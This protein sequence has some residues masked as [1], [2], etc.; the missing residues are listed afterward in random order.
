M[1]KYF[2]LIVTLLLLGGC[3]LSMEDWVLAEEDR[4]KEDPY[5]QH[6]E[7][8]DV[9]YQFQDSVLSVTAGIQEQYI[10]R[11]EHDSILYFNGNI[12]GKWRPYVGMKLAAGCSHQI[13]YGLNHRV[14][15]V[16][17]VGGIL[18]VVATKVETNEVYKHLSYCLDV[19][20]ATPNFGEMTEEELI[21]YGYELTIDP[22]TG[23]TL[24]MD[25]NDYDIQNG[26][27][28]AAAKRRSLK[29]LMAA[30][31]RADEENSNPELDTVK[32]KGNKDGADKTTYVDIMIDSRDLKG[33]KKGLDLAA[34]FMNALHGDFQ[35]A[36]KGILDKKNNDLWHGWEIQ[37]YVGMGLNV[38]GYSLAHIEQD[39]ATKTDVNYVDSWT[40]T[41]IKAEAGVDMKKSSETDFNQ[42]KSLGVPS[43]IFFKQMRVSQEKKLTLE[44]FTGR[45]QSW[46]NL[47]IRIVLPTTF[48]AAIV[49][50]STVTPDITI[51]GSVCG[52][53]TITG[54]KSRTG[55][56]IR[57]GVKK[58]E[59]KGKVID[60][61]VKTKFN[62]ALNGSIKI[63]ASYRASVGVE[64][65]GT[66]TT[67][68]GLNV[69]AF[70]TAE[71]KLEA[72]PDT[73]EG[74][75]STFWNHVSGDINASIDLYGD[76]QVA[77]APFGISL[78]NKQLAKFANI[79]LCK[80]HG[81]INPVMSTNSGYFTYSKDNDNITLIG[82]YQ[83][84]DMGLTRT[85]ITDN[86]HPGM[87]L[88]FGS[89]KSKSTKSVFMI[90]IDGETKKEL[91]FSQLPN[92]TKDQ[93][94][95]FK[96]VGNPSDYMEVNKGDGNVYMVPLL[97]N[98]SSKYFSD[99]IRYNWNATFKD[100]EKYVEVGIPFEDRKIPQDVRD[101][102]IET[103]KTGQVFGGPWP[104]DMDEGSYVKS[105][106][107]GDM[108]HYY[109]YST[110]K[111][112]GGSRLQEWGLSVKVY[113]D[114]IRAK[115]L[116][117]GKKSLAVN[118]LRSGLYTFVFD[119]MS[120]WEPTGP[121]D[122]LYYSVTPWWVKSDNL[123]GVEVASDKAS[124]TQHPI[125]WEF[126]DKTLWKDLQ[127]GK[128]TYGT[129]EWKELS[130]LS[131]S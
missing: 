57:N 105:G 5:T 85:F 80:L 69:D 3:T 18:K 9:T 118:K 83:F 60:K 77:V 101:G 84:K 42:N 26:L 34:P 15:S 129:V 131:G 25:W 35:N 27:R 29:R 102:C 72:N 122:R 49:I 71:G 43:G 36:V 124:Q 125:K 96:W 50:G 113:R 86:G 123:D 39:D 16:E 24:V 37:P 56:E 104:I 52:T 128:S 13:P 1:K 59:W 62:A 33:V 58:N 116:K 47:T 120:D 14:I 51:N 126:E 79:N 73:P 121:D 21:D 11:V 53:V 41:T 92:A 111:V 127:K 107:N 89:P 100:V 109:F 17:D 88:Y 63:G 110:V 74:S 6:T 119:F 19:G 87:K 130:S 4:G 99:D 10:V 44:N 66:F 68:I 48:P 22:E 70:V 108:R 112:A 55:H 76:I 93:M 65:A 90:P 28:P 30:R 32:V 45:K 12:P 115:P 67:S 94:Y 78:W 40:E 23:D 106:E 98:W 103:V 2:Y 91:R 97:F 7:Y 114:N 81:K 82:Y 64:L 54:K 8:G 46:N 117:G 61:N 95:T 31:T 38:T 75:E 20:L